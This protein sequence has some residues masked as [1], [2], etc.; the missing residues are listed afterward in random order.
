MIKRRSSSKFGD[1]AANDDCGGCSERLG[2]AR[3]ATFTSLKWASRAL[4]G[5]KGRTEQSV[6]SN[7]PVGQTGASF[8]YTFLLK[9]CRGGYVKESCMYEL[10][11]YLAIGG[12]IAAGFAAGIATGVILRN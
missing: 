4:F 6:K 9:L 10:F 11:F 8:T 2:P 5:A 7:A 12:C 1:F 3:F